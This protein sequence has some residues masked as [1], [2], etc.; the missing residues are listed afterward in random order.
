MD[1]KDSSTSIAE[2][3]RSVRK[4]TY[5]Q[6]YI[7]RIF[8]YRMRNIK[9]KII[10]YLR[11]TGLPRFSNWKSAWSTT[12]IWLEQC[13]NKERSTI[14]LEAGPW[15]SA[16]ESFSLQRQYSM[17][18]ATNWLKTFIIH[19]GWIA[20]LSHCCIPL[21]RRWVCV[22]VWW[23]PKMMDGSKH[24]TLDPQLLRSIIVEWVVQI[25]EWKINDQNWRR[26]LLGFHAY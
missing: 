17:Q 26:S 4:K 13:R 5:W 10:F 3:R 7:R 6:N 19:H 24:N 12:S 8:Y 22:L 25:N 1:T 18:Q 14:F 9:T 2:K 11:I 16:S 20:N 21:L 15:C 23:R